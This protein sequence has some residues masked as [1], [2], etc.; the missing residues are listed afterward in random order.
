MD[1]YIGSIPFK[2]KER[3]LTELFEQFGEVAS[4]TIILDKITRQ[5]KGFGF[6]TMPDE[7]SAMAAIK[8]LDGSEHE[9][10]AIAVNVSLPKGEVKKPFRQKGNVSK[11]KKP[12]EFKSGKH[13]KSL[14]PWLRKEY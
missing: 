8:A 11:D 6:V 2:W 9:G 10:R 14:P 1:I 12:M 5:N 7:A 13:K 3:D 4:A